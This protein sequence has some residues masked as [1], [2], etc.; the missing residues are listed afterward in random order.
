[1]REK[2]LITELIQKFQYPIMSSKENTCTDRHTDADAYISIGTTLWHGT[3]RRHIQTHR[4]IHPNPDTDT[5]ME[6][7]MHA[8][9]H[10]QKHIKRYTHRRKLSTRKLSFP[11]WKAI[12]VYN[13]RTFGVSTT[14]NKCSKPRDKRKTLEVSRGWRVRQMVT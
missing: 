2:N 5:D 7:H 14:I 9:T 10:K 3:Y 1:M 12:I 8:V 11:E 13:E 6:T 4:H